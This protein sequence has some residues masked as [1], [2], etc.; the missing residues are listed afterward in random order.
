[1]TDTKAYIVPPERTDSLPKHSSQESVNK[2]SAPS[3]KDR[4]AVQVLTHNGSVSSESE[5][6]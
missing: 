2:T 3:P 5:D 4:I 1:M 6:E